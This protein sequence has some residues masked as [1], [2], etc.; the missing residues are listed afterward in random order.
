MSFV[1]DLEWPIGLP[2]LNNGVPGT[3]SRDGLPT[4]R[5]PTVS[6]SPGTESNA[7]CGAALDGEGEDFTPERIVSVGV[8][9]ADSEF[10]S[11]VVMM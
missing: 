8:D 2:E 1:F 7:N 10:S 6:S 11:Q 4:Y 5:R 9:G 3:R